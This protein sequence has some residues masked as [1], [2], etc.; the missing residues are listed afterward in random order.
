M[1][2]GDKKALAQMLHLDQDSPLIDRTVD[3]I[4][5]L[6]ASGVPASMYKAPTSLDAFSIILANRLAYK[7]GE[8][9]MTAMQH[10][11]VIED[12]VTKK[13]VSQ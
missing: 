12:R 4:R 1:L 10:E 11:F 2:A 5:F 8:R 7:P 6:F 3:A 9:D 13:T